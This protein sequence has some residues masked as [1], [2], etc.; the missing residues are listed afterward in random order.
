MSNVCMCF[1]HVQGNAENVSAFVDGN[2]KNQKG[3]YVGLAFS[4]AIPAP[5]DADLEW[6]YENWGCKWETQPDNPAQIRDNGKEEA[7]IVFDTPNKPPLPWFETVA[8]M[9]PGVDLELRWEEQGNDDCGKA[10]IEDGLLCQI[11]KRCPE[12]E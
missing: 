7:L 10:W 1:L 12:L 6:A 4:A 8:G 5:D 11:P 3:E 2:R 9:Y